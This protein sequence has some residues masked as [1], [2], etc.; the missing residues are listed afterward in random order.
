MRNFSRIGILTV[1]PAA[2]ALVL[3]A[4]PLVRCKLA[5]AVIAT[6]LV[7]MPLW[8]HFSV[9][10]HARQMLK[11]EALA[12]GGVLHGFFRG[13]FWRNLAAFFF[14]MLLAVNLFFL[15]LGI[16]WINA[17]LLLGVALVAGR[18]F[19]PLLR[20]PLEREVKPDFAPIWTGRLP[21]GLV[22]AVLA[23]STLIMA[24]PGLPGIAPAA[25]GEAGS[26]LIG[27]LL[28]LKELK[29]GWESDIFSWLGKLAWPVVLLSYFGMWLALLMMAETLTMPPREFGRV[30]ARAVRDGEAYQRDPGGAFWFAFVVVIIT[31]P[32][33]AFVGQLESW[34]TE[35]EN[36][37][38]VRDRIRQLRAPRTTEL[39]SLPLEIPVTLP[40]EG[41]V[42]RVPS[43]SGQASR[44]QSLQPRF[45][46][47]GTRGGTYYEPGTRRESAK[48]EKACMK[49]AMERVKR[50]I[51]SIAEDEFRR[52]QS[53]VE[54]FLDWYY[55]LGGEYG[56]LKELI[57]GDFPS[58]MQGKFEEHLRLADASRRLVD[59]ITALE[60]S[61]RERCLKGR[62]ASVLDSRRIGEL[63]AGKRIVVAARIDDDMDSV[64]RVAARKTTPSVGRELGRMGGV[65]GA[66]IL[67]AILMKKL[68][69]KGTLKLAAK[70]A[71]K[72]LASKG[73]SSLAGG[74]VGALVGGVIGSIIPGPGTA[75]GAT[76]GGLVAGVGT[77]IVGDK[78]F[79]EMDEYFSRDEMRA[80]L[81][82]T[83][84]EARSQLVQQLQGSLAAAS[85]GLAYPGD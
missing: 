42:G 45:V 23:I 71:A 75:V 62:L 79:L 13:S 15:F 85:V 19:L 58:Y 27:W 77:S 18:V 74:G 37:F 73:A 72:A 29:E 36:R 82:E 52:M 83:L 2:L 4:G 78:I 12:E 10:G 7:A 35:L 28:A 33:L 60:K 38:Q 64:L 46:E 69:A 66:G 30:F 48:A 17:G 81:L 44:R 25:Q 26:A 22:A 16:G 54:S 14:A 61:E 8:I 57:L 5:A 1:S 56:R 53:G 63:P 76:I 3:A 84:A 59:R 9:L 41:Q 6:C 51:P 32:F 47:E 21:R 39:S 24:G 11:R 67:G 55:S 50:E 80:Q 43:P 31:G 68:I 34:A 70:A 65:A 20:Y 49:D 40:E